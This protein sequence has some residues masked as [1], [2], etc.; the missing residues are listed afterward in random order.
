[1]ESFR[2]MCLQEAEV[3]IPPHDRCNFENEDMFRSTEDRIYD[4]F[5]NRTPTATALIRRQTEAYLRTQAK[6]GI[7]GTLCVRNGRENWDWTPQVIATLRAR[8][9]HLCHKGVFVVDTDPLLP[10]PTEFRLRTA[11]RKWNTA[12]LYGEFAALWFFLLM[13]KD[14]CTTSGIAKSEIRDTF[15]F[16]LRAIEPGE[17]SDLYAFGWTGKRT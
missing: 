14:D 10:L 13:N 11:R 15:G 7:M 3:F 16:A 5:I 17:W 9:L 6:C 12:T 8:G 2:K 4:L 1:M